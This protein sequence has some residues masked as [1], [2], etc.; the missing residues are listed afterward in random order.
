ML[1]LERKRCIISALSAREGKTK[2]HYARAEI[3]RIHKV[4]RENLKG[5][6]ALG[7]KAAIL[8]F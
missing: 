1:N 8:N 3:L 2:L 6:T 4:L 5:S 7:K